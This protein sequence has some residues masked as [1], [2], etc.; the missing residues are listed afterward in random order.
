MKM[1]ETDIKLRYLIPLLKDLEE[2]N[3]FS[4]NDIIDYLVEILKGMRRKNE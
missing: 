3:V 4:W 1:S 2:P